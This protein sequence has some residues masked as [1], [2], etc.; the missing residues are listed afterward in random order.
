MTSVDNNTSGIAPLRQMTSN[1]NSSGL[2]P[3]RQMTSIDNITS[4]LAPPRQMT[5]DHNRSELETNDHSNEPLSS[6]LVPNV[7][8]IA[9]TTDSLQQELDFL[10]SPLYEEYFT[11]GN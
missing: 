5:S 3:Q 2:V 7:C 10:F 6:K 1:H 11:T 4:G 9:D 8:P